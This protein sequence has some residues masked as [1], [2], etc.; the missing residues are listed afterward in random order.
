MADTI[1]VTVRASGGDYT[2]LSAAESGEQRD[3]VSAD[4]IALFDVG[5][6]EDAISFNGITI[7]GWTTDA[8]RY[9]IVRGATPTSA[10]WDT[11]RYR[12]VGPVYLGAL[13]INQ[14]YT[15]IENVQVR[16]T[17][18]NWDD[19]GG[20]HA[21]V[22]NFRVTGCWVENACTTSGQGLDKGMGIRRINQSSGTSVI[23][24]NIVTGRWV[25]GIRTYT[26]TGTLV[27]YHNTVVGL[28]AGQAL[29]TDYEGGTGTTVRVY[30]NI[31]QVSGSAVCYSTPANYVG[32]AN[33]GNL[34][35]DATSPQTA[36]RNITLDFAGAGDYALDPVEDT[37]AIGAGVD[38]SGD[39]T[40]PVT[41]DILGTT[42]PDPPSIGAYEPTGG[43]G[44]DLKS[45]SDSLTL[46]LT[47]ASVLLASL[48]QTDTLGLTVSEAAAL[49]GSL[50]ATDTLAVAATET[51]TL[52]VEASEAE[53][54]SVG[55][56]E[57]AGLTTAV[58]ASDVLA[59]A[60]TETPSAEVLALASDTLPLD[61]TDMAA[62]TAEVAASDTLPL[63][64]ADVPVI[65]VTLSPSDALTLTVV[66]T[67]DVDQDAAP[68]EAKSAS[69]T[70]SVGMAEAVSAL[71]ALVAAADALGLTA[72][73][74]AS[75][76]V[77][78][79]TGDAL[80]VT[81]SDAPVL[82]VLIDTS[83]A[84]FLALV[85]QAT[86]DAGLVPIAASDTLSVSLSSLPVVAVVA[87]AQDALHAALAEGAALEALVA[88]ADVAQV[89]VSEQGAVSATAAASDQ[90]AVSA[91]LEAALAW[92]LSASDVLS[93]ALGETIQVD[94]TD[95][96][97]F[98]VA[99]APR[100]RWLLPTHTLR[101]RL[102]AYGLRCG[103]S[104]DWTMTAKIT[105][106]R[107]EPIPLLVEVD[108]APIDLTG[109][110][111][112]LIARRRDGTYLDTTGQLAAHPDQSAE[113]GHRGEVYWSPADTTT[114]R[115]ADG[116][117]TL[118]VR[119]EHGDPI[120]RRH[121]AES[122]P[123]ILSVLRA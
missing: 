49:V 121:H 71:S 59:L 10:T 65:L 11:S 51:P 25:R 119:V 36:L 22:N 34:S 114:I 109:L 55:S 116:P 79:D 103:L 24:N 84:A 15:R 32:T 99:R 118:R 80:S 73:E 2:S 38:L 13:N 98:V 17:N 117:L 90:L 47:D 60:S 48:I 82:V 72:S 93:L 102:P 92:H 91:A 19:P 70:L 37:E 89:A 40:Y 95:V 21:G 63:S 43:G 8:T 94:A 62:L 76:A 14:E 87:V 85:E 69:D 45:A 44:P 16:V 57:V 7:A 20:I 107:T 74:A 53:S 122:D 78:A 100:L 12:I 68:P 18:H 110:T 46:T 81:V 96:P 30:N 88:G 52:S 101:S 9:V 4:E 6:L 66:E 64:L 35:S 67:A 113:G 39:A 75:L 56:S 23:A 5:D 61:V 27:Q 42:R 112:S 33:G 3:L 77:E 83:E 1:T 28:Q 31:A 29:Q 106:G 97:V 105:E 111:L 41:T 50:T 108:G 123:L 104:G 86:L 115:V 54:L 120:K 58:E 26:I